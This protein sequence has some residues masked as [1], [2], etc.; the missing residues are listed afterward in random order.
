MIVDFARVNVHHVIIVL[1][2][3]IVID[4]NASVNHD[5]AI[6]GHDIVIAALYFANAEYDCNRTV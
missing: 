1:D 5:N 2:I 6:A 3:A 4:H